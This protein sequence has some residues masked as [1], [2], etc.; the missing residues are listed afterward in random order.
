VLIVCPLTWPVAG[1]PGTG[2]TQWLWVQSRDGLTPIAH[3]TDPTALLPRD[4]DLVLVLPALFLSWHRVVL[5]RIQS[6][7][8]RQALDGLLEDRLL[9][10]PATL[11]LALEPQ[12]QAGQSAWV[13]ACDKATLQH[14][15]A[16]LQAAQRPASRLA[17]ELPPQAS[18]GLQALTQNGQAWLMWTG[19]NGVLHW[20]LPD[21]AAQAP[22]AGALATLNHWLVETPA[23]ERRAEPACA[24]LAEALIQQP[25]QV[26][27]ADQRLLRC[28]Q[29]AWD[30]AQFDLRLSSAERRRQ[31]M[32]QGLRQLWHAPV[33]RPT[34]W[35]VAALIA[36]MLLGLNLLA[37]QERKNLADLHTQVHQLLTTT[38]THVTLVLDAP[39]Q[40]H[41]ELA[42][43]QRSRGGSSPDDLEALL[44]DLAHT[45][46]TPP[47][48][49]SI[50]HSATETRLKLAPAADGAVSTLREAL[51]QKGWRT[52][53]SA[54]TLTLRYQA[55]VG[56][57]T[58][59]GN[60]P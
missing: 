39:L 2:S 44:Q 56:A 55:K 53:F 7:R 4:N 23:S 42:T 26:E 6:S 9:A 46:G 47:T 22:A 24:A 30:L 16:Q 43:L 1:Q 57:G 38:F 54:P 29:G 59:Q 25:M 15:L 21:A 3:G 32:L 27:P 60:K 20:P 28:T 50:D 13:A 5:P 58:P 12:A 45:P 51:G 14:W 18:A 40:M 34:R 10:D 41:R 33:W 52:E 8:M 48:I 31:G 49:L 17:P 36:S 35:G 37:W 11:H 19:P